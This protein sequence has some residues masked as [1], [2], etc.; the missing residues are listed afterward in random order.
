MNDDKRL[1]SEVKQ[2]EPLPL[3][4]RL[5]PCCSGPSSQLAHTP[6]FCSRACEEFHEFFEPVASPEL[7]ESEPD[8]KQV[9]QASGGALRWELKQE[10]GEEE[11]TRL[12]FLFV[13][14]PDSV[15]LRHGGQESCHIP[16]LKIILIRACNAV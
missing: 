12:S 3:Y 2:S 1:L 16:I 6:S 8:D 13:L 14:R 5:S 11:A 10:E 4:L 15:A 9:R 7:Q